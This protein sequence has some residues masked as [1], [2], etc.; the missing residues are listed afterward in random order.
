MVFLE[1]FFSAKFE[2]RIL[3]LNNFI[4]AIARSA[5]QQEHMEGKSK[6]SG[7][8]NNRKGKSV[9]TNENTNRVDLLSQLRSI[10]IDC[11]T[12]ATTRGEI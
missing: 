4:D 7:L 5:A 8:E 3:H 12:L 6:V 2:N 9:L 11:E 1:T 10:G